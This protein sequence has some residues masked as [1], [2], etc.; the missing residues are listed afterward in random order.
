MPFSCAFGGEVCKNLGWEFMLRPL[1]S[2]FLSLEYNILSLSFAV[3][4]VAN[5]GS[6]RNHKQLLMGHVG[7]EGCF[8]CK[9]SEW[10]P[11][12][13]S[14]FSMLLHFEWSWTWDSQGSMGKLQFLKETLSTSFNLYLCLAISFHDRA[15]NWVCFRSLQCS[16]YQWRGTQKVKEVLQRHPVAIGWNCKTTASKYLSVEINKSHTK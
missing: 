13:T 11:C 7:H 3:L 15:W 16:I 5:I 10:F 12:K 2:Q 1:N 14:R 4:E 9:A 6:H 8:L